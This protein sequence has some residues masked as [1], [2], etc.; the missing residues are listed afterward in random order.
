[1]KRVLGNIL[2]KLILGANKELKSLLFHVVKKENMKL[3]YDKYRKVYTIHNSF[4]FNGD[5]IRFYGEGQIII[6]ENTYIGSYS[7]IQ[8]STGTMV[9]IGNNCSI[10][11][12]VR[13][14]TSSNN[15][16]QNIDSKVPGCLACHS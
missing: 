6:G 14:Y 7:S 9:T 1:M 12:G 13:I 15:A 3:I 11:H 16:N 4:K 10:S 2:I 8:S 5:F